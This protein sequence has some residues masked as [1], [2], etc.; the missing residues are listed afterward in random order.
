MVRRIVVVVLVVVL[1][2]FGPVAVYELE[3]PRTN[4][5]GIIVKTIL[6]LIMLRVFV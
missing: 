5:T 1:L 6:V 3:Y 4:C 2:L